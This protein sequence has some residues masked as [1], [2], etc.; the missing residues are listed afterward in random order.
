MEIAVRFYA[1]A[2]TLVLCV[3]LYRL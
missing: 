1:Y 3:C 2:P